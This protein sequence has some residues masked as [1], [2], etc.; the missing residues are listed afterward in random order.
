MNKQGILGVFGTHAFLDGLCD[1]HLMV[2]ASGVRPFSASEGEFL[3]REGQSADA[4]YLIQSGHVELCTHT[5]EGEMVPIQRV[6]PGEVVGWSWVLPPNK[7]QFDCL[8]LDDVQG[9]KFDAGWL[10]ERCEQ[11]HELGYCLLRH[12]LAVLAGRLAATRRHLIG[13]EEN[14]SFP[15][16]VSAAGI[17]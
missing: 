2:L 4:F 8:A 7:W 12:L 11:D 15:K 5:P 14:S 13:L 3:A 9:L 17:W 16:A 6:G 1:R 10:R